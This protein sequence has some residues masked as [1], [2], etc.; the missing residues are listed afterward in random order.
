MTVK[1]FILKNPN[2]TLHLMTP[3][4]YVDLNPEQTRRLLEGGNMMSHPG[5]SGC[6]MELPA[7]VVLSQFICSC[8]MDQE[9]HQCFLLTGLY[10]PEEDISPKDE[11]ECCAIQMM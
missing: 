8:N 9:N 10:P 1:D 6:D 4:G 7:D 2:L 3:A 5:C 11:N